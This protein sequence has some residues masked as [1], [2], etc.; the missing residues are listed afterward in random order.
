M[1]DKTIVGW[2]EDYES[3]MTEEQSN[4]SMREFQEL[5][6]KQSCTPPPGNPQFTDTDPEII[7]ARQLFNDI[8]FGKCRG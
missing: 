8:I 6:R 5:V 7:K 4:E 3:Y 1:A 2:D